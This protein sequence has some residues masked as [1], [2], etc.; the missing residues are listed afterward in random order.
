MGL[1]PTFCFWLMYRQNQTLVDLLAPSITAMGYDLLGIE[2]L[3]RG[4]ES[5][6]RIYIDKESGIT[7]DDCER[8]SNQVTGILDVED[9]VS[10]SYRLEVS[11]PGLDRPLFNLEQFQQFMG[12]TV[13]IRLRSKFEG[14]RKL[15]GTIETVEQDVVVIRESGDQYRLPA[16][17]IEHAHL[18]PDL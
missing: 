1:A 2:Q 18:Q 9:P 13:S 3:A 16:D 6:V 15:T 8:V 11:S 12:Q 10:G 14:R 4:R 5:L 7:L 17:V